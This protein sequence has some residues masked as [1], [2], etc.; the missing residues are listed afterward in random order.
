MPCDE[1]FER[2]SVDSYEAIEEMP[3]LDISIK[4]ERAEQRL[5]DNPIEEIVLSPGI[6]KLT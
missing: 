2:E 6:R 5:K 3:V 4:I 1:E